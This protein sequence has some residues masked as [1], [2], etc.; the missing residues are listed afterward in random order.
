MIY[1]YFVICSPFDLVHW[2]HGGVWTDLQVKK[3]E[4]IIGCIQTLFQKRVNSQGH[5]NLTWYA[6]PTSKIMPACE[7][8]CL[9]A[10]NKFLRKL[11]H[12]YDL[13]YFWVKLAHAFK[14]SNF[15]CRP[16]RCRYGISSFISET[17]TFTLFRNIVW[18]QPLV[19]DKS[20][21]WMTQMMQ[22]KNMN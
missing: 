22:S 18:I 8:E 16:F 10:W 1:R 19:S 21:S 13:K 4:S 6:E 12:K 15:T 3:K 17:L 14:H 9:N 5:G 7:I 20:F 11:S 2:E